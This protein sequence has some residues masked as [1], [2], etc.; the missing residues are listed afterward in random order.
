MIKI[1]KASMA[2]VILTACTFLSGCFG[3]EWTGF[4]YPNRHDLTQHES[5]GTFKSLEDC[6]LSSQLRLAQLNAT[7]RGDYECGLNC[8]PSKNLPGMNVCDETTR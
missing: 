7:R 3:D 4:I 8:R 6:R 2:A 5:I 1:A